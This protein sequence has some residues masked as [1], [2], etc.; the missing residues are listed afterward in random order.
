MKNLKCSREVKTCY[1][2][3]TSDMLPIKGSISKCVKR[4]NLKC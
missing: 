4:K 2:L 3:A 1:R